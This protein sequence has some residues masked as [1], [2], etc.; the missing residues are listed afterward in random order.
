MCQGFSDL[1]VVKLDS[2]HILVQ[3]K[4]WKTDTKVQKSALFLSAFDVG[5]W[6]H[7]HQ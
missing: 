2:I 6:D 7:Y 1:S 3:R 4:I 5:V